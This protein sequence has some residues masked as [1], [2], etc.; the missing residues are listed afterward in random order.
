MDRKYLLIIILLL[1]GLCFA[2][3]ETGKTLAVQTNE[4]TDEQ[5]PPVPEEQ[6][7]QEDEQPVP[8]EI[9]SRSIRFLDVSHKLITEK[10]DLL[11]HKIDVFFGGERA[12]DEA[13]GSFIELN[14]SIQ[15]DEGTPTINR[16][17]VRAKLELPN[18]EKK[19]SLRFENEADGTQVSSGGS[20]LTSDIIDTTSSAAFSAV[21]QEGKL[22]RFNSDVGVRFNVGFEPFVRFRGHGKQQFDVWR[23]RLKGSLLWK[24]SEGNE[25]K[26]EIDFERPIGEAF[27]FRVNSVA[28]WHERVHE[29]DYGHSIAL[30]QNLGRS[31][32]IVYRISMR[33]INDPAEPDKSYTIDLAY[34]KRIYKDWVFMEINPAQIYR[35]ENDFERNGQITF[36]IQAMFSHKKH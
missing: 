32:G 28:V 10:F 35:E 3:N 6:L 2:Q 27:F 31:R 9:P 17:K 34:R 36:S 12:Y 1:P 20:Q 7:K 21:L 29:T 16:S 11:A 30:Y 22:W 25:I 15:K 23:S 8:D 14:L 19:L 5:K 13:T 33:D 4:H 24:E 18:T 26:T